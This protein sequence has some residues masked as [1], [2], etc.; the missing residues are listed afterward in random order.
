MRNKTL[1]PYLA[2]MNG[3]LLVAAPRQLHT[4]AWTHLVLFG[5]RNRTL[6]PYLAVMNGFHISVTATRWDDSIPA[7]RTPYT[8]SVYSVN[9]MGYTCS[10][11]EF[12]IGHWVPIRQRAHSE[13]WGPGSPYPRP[14]PAQSATAVFP[15]QKPPLEHQPLPAHSL[16]ASPRSDLALGPASNPQLPQVAAPICFVFLC[17]V[18]FFNPPCSMCPPKE[19][20]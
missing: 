17:F 19:H 20:P 9:P 15:L 16:C 10:Y 13:Q 18:L 6:D 8:W 7:C 14:I 12:R 1:D 4:P 5:I 11:L 3:I 2:V